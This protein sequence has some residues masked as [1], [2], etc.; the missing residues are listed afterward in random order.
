[1]RRLR[2]RHRGCQRRF[3]WPR[4]PWRARTATRM[5]RHIERPM[6]EIACDSP[7]KRRRGVYYG[8]REAEWQGH[9]NVRLQRPAAEAPLLLRAVMALTAGREPLCLDMSVER[10][11]SFYGVL[12]STPARI[13]ARGFL[14]SGSAH[15]LFWRPSIR[16]S[17]PAR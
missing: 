9:G 13:A 12:S 11:G 7:I 2:L 16:G 1:M 5:R 17:S 6:F 3:R 14:R 8:A 4:P 10:N 15:D